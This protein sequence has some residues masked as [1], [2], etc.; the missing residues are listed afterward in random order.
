MFI[1]ALIFTASI[2]TSIYDDVLSAYELTNEA[3]NDEYWVEGS[4][5]DVIVP[6]VFIDYDEPFLARLCLNRIRSG[7]ELKAMIVS[8][9]GT[10]RF[11]CFANGESKLELY[12]LNSVTKSVTS[13]L[14]GIAIDKGFIHSVHDSIAMYLPDHT[15]LL[16]EY[17]KTVT[18]EDLL[19]M[20]SPIGNMPLFAVNDGQS[21][22]SPQLEA[23]F[24]APDPVEFI[25]GFGAAES[26][27]EGFNYGEG[28]AT[29]VGRIIA[30]ATGVSVVEFAK[31]NLFLPMGIKYFEWHLLAD[32]SANTAG[33]LVLTSW[34]MLKIGELVQNNGAWSGDQ[35]VN[36]HWIKSSIAP[37]I[38]TRST[39]SQYGYYWWSNVFKLKGKDI[40]VM[41]ARGFKGQFILV[42]PELK[43][44]I[45]INGDHE[46]FNDLGGVSLVEYIIKR[47]VPRLLD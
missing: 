40:T 17:G 18:I 23:Y 16:G 26:G 36:A 29:L 4:P 11:N 43:A 27:I 32:G 38:S 15:H 42:I 24:A 14:V 41:A 6:E 2:Y 10:I 13:L 22:F 47:Y 19:L 31:Q 39:W 28:P 37:H 3:H 7:D 44:T 12:G 1:F 5:S 20:K 9:A 46:G 21:A 35:L 34:D 25:L 30:N 33:G 8:V 45:A